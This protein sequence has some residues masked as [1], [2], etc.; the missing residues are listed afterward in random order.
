MNN[1]IWL[2]TQTQAKQG[3]FFESKYNLM[4]IFDKIN[5]VKHISS[6]SLMAFLSQATFNTTNP[7]EN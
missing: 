3:K 4:S 1:C 2:N 7:F 6:L 5:I